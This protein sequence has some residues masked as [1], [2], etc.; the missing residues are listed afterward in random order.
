MTERTITEARADLAQEALYEISLIS[1]QVRRILADLND[2]EAE[3][4]PRGMLARI[5]ELSRAVSAVVTPKMD[6]RTD[7]DLTDVVYC[8]N[9]PAH[10]AKAEAT[11]PAPSAPHAV[12]PASKRAAPGVSD[13]ASRAYFIVS[14]AGVVTDA[15]DVALQAMRDHV[16]AID[17][18]DVRVAFLAVEA[19]ADKMAEALKDA[20]A[21]LERAGHGA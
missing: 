8:G 14:R 15:A 16:D 4:V 9:P 3:L 6:D 12:L 19:C 11:E 10:L 13:A 21:E 17:R 20:E 18:A 1:Q 7:A 2:T 5:E